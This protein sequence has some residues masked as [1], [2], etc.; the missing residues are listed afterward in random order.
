MVAS[1]ILSVS[2]SRRM[3]ARLGAECESYGDLAGSPHTA[4]EET[5]SR[6]WRRRAAS[7]SGDG[8]GQ[9]DQAGCVTSPTSWSRQRDRP[10]A[11]FGTTSGSVWA[12]RPEHVRQVVA[13]GAQ[14]DRL[15]SAERSTGA[16]CSRGHMDRTRDSAASGLPDLRTRHRRSERRR[17][18]ADDG[19]RL[20]V[21]RQRVVRR[22]PG[23]HRTAGATRRRSGRPRGRR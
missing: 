16:K 5:D 15:A 12:A 21:Q 1:T 23:P 8:P 20:V 13:R 22:S 17:H 14:R 19:P 9:N 6:D 7:T 11:E 4:D 10:R 18:D 2:N 3:R